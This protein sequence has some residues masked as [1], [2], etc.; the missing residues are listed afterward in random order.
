M[1]RQRLLDCPFFIPI[2]RDRHL[3]DGRLHS[4]RSWDWLVNCL[5][6]FG[7]ATRDTAL[8]AGCYV[9]PDTEEGVTDRSRRQVTAVARKRLGRLRAVLREAGS[10]FRQKCIYLSVAGYVQFGQ[11]PSHE[12]R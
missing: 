10:V 4:P 3:P 2:R 9:D 7:G 11:G 12:S 1:A 8:H 6:E 5:A